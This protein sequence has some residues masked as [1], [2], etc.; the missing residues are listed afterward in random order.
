MPTSTTA[1]YCIA[2][3]MLAEELANAGDPSEARRCFETYQRL[4]KDHIF[5]QKYGALVEGQL[6]EAEGRYPS[7]IQ[8]YEE[9]LL[10]PAQQPL[11]HM[12]IAAIRLARLSRENCRL[13]TYTRL[14]SRHVKPSSWI[15]RSLRN[16][17]EEQKRSNLT[18][19]QREYIAL[20]R[21]G[22]TNSEIAKVR[23]RSPH[24]VRNQISVLFE[25]F[26]VRNRA[27]LVAATTKAAEVARDD[28]RCRCRTTAI[29]QMNLDNT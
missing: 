20:I 13:D 1:D 24:T 28:V 23:A 16:V 12:L 2:A 17:A 15:Y 27:E 29:V 9:V 21:Q 19:L 4:A 18:A 10:R 26:D 8:L 22:Y 7:A 25:V 14:A 3:L 5:A 6:A 11:R